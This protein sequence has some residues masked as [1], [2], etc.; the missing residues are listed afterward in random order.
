MT[1]PIVEIASAHDIHG[2]FLLVEDGKVNQQLI[3]RLLERAGATVDLADNGQIGVEKALSS[4]GDY[5]IILLDMQMPVMD[6]YTAAQHLRAAGYRGPIIA[7][8]ADAMT[9]NRNRCLEAGCDD[10]ATKPIDRGQ[11]V[12]DHSP[13]PS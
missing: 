4:D 3:K 10:F 5:D 2:R 8:T 13:F 9:S 11:A 6:G 1:C 7:L 12:P